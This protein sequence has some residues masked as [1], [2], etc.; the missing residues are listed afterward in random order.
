MD[1]TDADFGASSPVYLAAVADGGRGLEGRASLPAR[2]PQ[3]GRHG[4]QLA[5]LVL[6]TG[7]R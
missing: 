2:Q 4:G 3:P 5:D 1:T 7:G 6:A